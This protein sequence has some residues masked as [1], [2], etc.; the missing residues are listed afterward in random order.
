MVIRFSSVEFLFSWDHDFSNTDLLAS[1][2]MLLNRCLIFVVCVLV[3]LISSFS[4]FLF[5]ENISV[6]YKLVHHY[7]G[8]KIYLLLFNLLKTIQHDIPPSF[9]H[10]AVYFQF[11]ISKS[12][13]EFFFSAPCLSRSFKL[14]YPHSLA[15]WLPIG[16]REWGARTGRAE[17]LT[18]FFHGKQSQPLATSS[19]GRLLL[20][21]SSFH[22]VT[23]IC[24]F[25]VL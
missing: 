2:W 10:C 6:C 16:F 3:W 21:R 25:R 9:Y 13:S 17:A 22:L 11:A 8:M 19:V 7:M 20:H 1:F 24:P 12:C 18:P 4:S 23:V 15:V 5:W 14:Y